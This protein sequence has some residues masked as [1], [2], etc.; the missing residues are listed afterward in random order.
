MHTDFLLVAMLIAV[1][2]ESSSI[3]FP[4]KGA[5][6]LGF[7]A[8]LTLESIS[9]LS[10]DGASK[11]QFVQ[12]KSS[13]WRL[14]AT[15]CTGPSL[16]GGVTL[17]P[18]DAAS[19]S[20]TLS[21]EGNSLSLVWHGVANSLPLG[22]HGALTVTINMSV[23]GT[24]V[25][26]RGSVA[27]DDGNR[28]NNSTATICVQTLTLPTLNSIPLSDNDTMFVPDYFGHAGECAG[29]C[30]LNLHKT[31]II[32][33]SEFSYM[34]NGNSRAMQWLAFYGNAVT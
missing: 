1:S 10:A 8:S 2:A 16:P 17:M 23:Y 14:T 19:T 15:N 7:D 33:A 26:M 5:F 24:G 18:G 32:N 9:M 12:S 28:S 31:A 11:Q 27:L 21:P 29:L 30:E 25:A 22:L 6:Q 34:P 20:H 13:L 4:A 3:I